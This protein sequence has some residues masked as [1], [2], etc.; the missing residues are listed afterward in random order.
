MKFMFIQLLVAAII[1]MTSVWFLKSIETH[2]LI[3]NQQSL[4]IKTGKAI[5]A[6]LQQKTNRIEN[7]AVSI[8]ALGELYRDT[9]TLLDGSIPALLNPL[10]HEDVILG[11]GI[12]PDP[13]AFDNDIRKYSHFWARSESGQLVKIDDYNEQKSPGY[14]NESWYAPS[15]YFPTD[16]TYWSKSYVDPFTQIPMVTA[17]VPM[18]SNHQF[19]GVSTVDIALA[20]LHN[21][22]KTA[23]TGQRGYVFALDQQNRLLS[24]PDIALNAPEDIATKELLLPFADFAELNG[25]FKPLQ[26]KVEQIDAEFIQQAEIDKAYTT[27]QLIK[28]TEK[29]PS[30]EQAKLTAIIN[31][32]AKQKL[33]TAQLIGTVELKDD[34]VFNEPVIVTLFLMPGTYW[35]VI[36]VTPITAI[37]ASVESMTESIGLYLVAIQIFALMLLFI[38]QNKL[39]I[40]PITRM[41]NALNNSNSAMI[42][43]ESNGRTDEIGLLAKAFSSRTQQLE[44]ALSSLD[45]TNLALENQL[46][47]QQL[48]QTDLKESKEQLNLIL[49]SAHNLIFIKSVEGELTLVNDQFCQVA[50]LQRNDILGV[51]V[52]L[53][54]PSEVSRI[55]NDYDKQVIENKQELSY[56]QKIKKDRELHTYLVTKF[57]ILD[58]QQQVVSVGTIAFDISETKSIELENKAQ[59]EKL[60]QDNNDSTA[61]IKKLKQANLQLKNESIQTRSQLN[62]EIN[63]EKVILDNQALYPNLIASLV[64]PIF[65]EQDEL[66]ANAY[67]FSNGDLDFTD[68]SQELAQQTERLRHLEYLLSA[69][70]SSAKPIDLVQLLEHI[71]AL[72]QP[73]LAEL[74][75]VIESQTDKRLIVDG[76]HWHYLLMLYRIVSNTVTDAFEFHQKN[77]RIKVVL[78]KHNNDIEI[79]V[80]DNGK[81]L[82]TA[83]LDQLQQQ[84]LENEVSGSLTTLSVWLK[85]EFN[86]KL[87]ITTLAVEEQYT[88]AV[89]CAVSIS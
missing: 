47:V 72:L 12:W 30:H 14:H 34:P 42:E 2:R 63:Y 35:K 32:N 39:F 7:L 60:I 20:N 6:T 59:F 70:G 64:K 58:S 17:S 16:T 73:K 36:L 11:G 19:I 1:I 40:N 41:V 88:T 9:P 23:L 79:T 62:K 82:P 67:R 80:Y 74:N 29:F 52:H 15:K 65:R 81:G 21:F 10:G 4:N 55:N 50:G 31:Q 83:L 75:I 27:E 78:Q 37:E 84:I 87:Q 22:F 49:N 33:V 24:Y 38:V 44:I 43:L 5:T 48:A 71:T 54:L 77:K 25:S 46:E 3:D 85:S 8:S 76:I 68:I 28:V 26:Q 89:S 45:A 69:Q 18:W 61:I 86:G 13:N 56:E 53:V 66:A 51:K 57:P